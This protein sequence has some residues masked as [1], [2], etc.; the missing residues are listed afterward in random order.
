MEHWQVPYLGIRQIPNE[1][2]EFEL[3]TFF[4]FSNKERALIDSRR[5]NL[6][7]LAVAL[8]IGFLR[9]S[10]RTLDAYKQIPKT[11]WAHLGIQINVDPPEVSTLRALYQT[12]PRTLTDHQV[13]AYEALGFGLMTE[14]QRRYILRWL[15]ETLPR[16]LISVPC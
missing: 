10:G 4:T 3:N 1:L 6:Y 13:V 14:H 11:L 9:M 5:N 8:H 15:K 12:R 16:G 2:N 7:R